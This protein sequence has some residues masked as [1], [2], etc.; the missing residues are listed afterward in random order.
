[1]DPV[2]IFG[3]G[4]VAF[5][6]IAYFSWVQQKKRRV[7]IAAL[8]AK[9]DLT[10]H[11]GKDRSAVRQF[12]FLDLIRKGRNRYAVKSRD[13]KFAYDFCNARMIN[14]LLDEQDLNIEV[15]GAWLALC[16]AKRIP[17]ED[18]EKNFSRLGTML[19]LMP[20]YLFETEVS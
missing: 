15:Q 11:P 3:L 13:K 14:F 20:T 17:P 9:L 4:L 12:E 19:G 16:F 10:F 7:A 2:L 6:I 5:G 18:W 8:G 1:M